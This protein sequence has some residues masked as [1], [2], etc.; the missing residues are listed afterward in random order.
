MASNCKNKQLPELVLKDIESKVK[1]LISS[2]REN[3]TGGEN[4]IEENINN[5]NN[6][7]NLNAVIELENTY[8][9]NK[10]TNKTT[11]PNQDQADLYY[12]KVAMAFEV[13]QSANFSMREKSKDLIRWKEDN[14]KIIAMNMAPAKFV[15]L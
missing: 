15:E 14:N 2:Q 6:N 3:D 7:N 9:A 8:N 4:T 11:N 12:A 13:Q 5:H 1:S 10:T